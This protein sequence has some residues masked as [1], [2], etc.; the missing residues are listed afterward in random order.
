MT[1]GSMGRG[2][3]LDIVREQQRASW[4]NGE[5]VLV[6]TL[7]D[8]YPSLGG[9]DSLVELIYSEFCLRDSIGEEVSPVDY[10]ERFPEYFERLQRLFE[11]HEALE[12][13][14]P[15]ITEAVDVEKPSDASEDAFATCAVA[16]TPAGDTSA[17]GRL[18]DFELLDEIARGG[19]GVVYKAW[20]RGADRVVALK[21]ILAGRFA[22][23]VEI[24]RFRV[25]AQAAARLDHVNI[26]PIFSVGD[27]DSHP[28][29]AMAYIDGESLAQR[30][31]RGPIAPREASALLCDIASGVQYAHQSGIVH[32]DLK[33]ANILLTTDGVPKITDFG[34][35]KRLDADGL[36]ATGD[37]LGTPA[38]MAPEHALGVRSEPE[39]LG[40]I[41]SL[42]AILYCLLTGRPPF[43]AASAVETMKQVVEQ[44]PVAPRSMNPAIDRDI[45]TIC[46]KCLEKEPSRRYQ[47]ASDL[48]DDLQRY[49]S[50]QPIQA[51]QVSRVERMWRWCK[52]RPLVAMLAAVSSLL[53]ISLIAALAVGNV[54]QAKLRHKADDS[55][56][57]ARAQADL[58]LASLERIVFDI[59]R[60]LEH[61]PAAQ[62]VRREM[63]LSV[64]EQLDR[65]ASNLATQDL[66]DHHT[67]VA[68]V[69]L[70]D[71]YLSIGSHEGISG[72]EQ[73]R[74]AYETANKAFQRMHET[75]PRN[76]FFLHNLAISYGKLAKV[77][78]AR[79]TLNKAVHFQSLGLEH[80]KNLHQSYP[81]NETYAASLAAAASSL[82]ELEFNRGNVQKARELQEQSRRILLPLSQNEA[83]SNAHRRSLAVVHNFLG[84]IYLRQSKLQLAKESYEASLE[85]REALAGDSHSHDNLESQYD[86]AIGLRRYGDVLLEQADIEQ[87]GR[88]YQRSLDVIVRA[89]TADPSHR[90]VQQQLATSHSK[91]GELALRMGQVAKAT[92]HFEQVE[93]IDA[94][95]V[96]RH[97]DSFLDRMDLAAAK[98]TL[99]DALMRTGDLAAAKRLYTEAFAIL[100]DLRSESDESSLVLENY[101]A[102]CLRLGEISQRTGDLDAA[103]QWYERD[104]ALE[105]ELVA[106]TPNDHAK[107]RGVSV[108]LG[109]VGDLKL[110]QLDIDRA[111]ASYKE[112]LAI[113]RR[114]ATASPDS[115]QAQRDLFVS[116]AR[117]GSAHQN[118]GEYELAKQS[119][120]E[121]LE[122]AEGLATIGSSDAQA[123]EDLASAL[124][125]AAKASWY[126]GDNA[127]AREA[128]EQS[129][130][131][132][133]SLAQRDSNDRDSQYNLSLSHENLFDLLWAMGEIETAAR[134]LTACTEIRERL[135]T[136]S[137]GDMQLMRARMVTRDRQGWI[138][139]R[140][141]DLAAAQASYESALEILESML[142]LDPSNTQARVDLVGVVFRL[143][144]LQ[145]RQFEFAEA[146]E[147]F[148]RSLLTL[149]ELEHDGALAQQP[150]LKGYLDHIPKHVK[151]CELYDQV[152]SDLEFVLKQDEHRVPQLLYERS[153]IL[154]KRRDYESAALTIETLV[155][156]HVPDETESFAEDQYSAACGYGLCVIALD[157]Q[158]QDLA[159][160]ED[161]LALRQ[162]FV[163]RAEQLLEAAASNGYFL[164]DEAAA[165]LMED[166]DFRSLRDEFD[167]SRF[168]DP[169]A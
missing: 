135:A 35:A 55:A 22:T 112:S 50:N 49:L 136:A 81:K 133:E 156:L 143:A 125:G 146:K 126:C 36:T 142:E 82:G 102:T 113:A 77:E 103:A 127:S 108:G 163:A 85:L 8:E 9:D 18:A 100:D 88:F 140:H 11:V 96:R 1:D 12:R 62:S 69:E 6:E 131:I 92:R 149:R 37:I 167:S 107:W 13:G 66:A 141:G 17:L 39:V 83:P 23:E 30:V 2:E 61:V 90:V 10:L 119:F 86:L 124:A 27:D 34:L 24:Q 46:L 138:D 155:K 19:M 151:V 58:A 33:P 53:A 14:A 144:Y 169:E 99:G 60:K 63:L 120:T 41:Y 79:G 122:T 84:T 104:L 45:E 47:S 95:L 74:V 129:L 165:W 32:R 64:I 65:V 7:L 42:G 31:A 67:A 121:A 152:A 94:E 57:T 29:F 97:P 54:Y 114:L 28:Y 15:D 147:N 111:L 91:V 118:H 161:E 158:S 153:M 115:C 101:L 3:L 93:Q 164:D 70:G 73:A 148:D 44:E 75:D 43:Q 80:L 20:Q 116:L 168:V 59:Q 117:V 25:E 40:D 68:H 48:R 38:Y 21:M 139:E 162:R 89:A 137:H 51:R 106:K 150:T 105:R 72:E 98:Q 56:T 109:R 52:R 157:D 71:I 87:A 110:Q 123:D 134:H 132:R 130:A 160:R 145:Q 166:P 159:L 4:T 128:F 76:D 5:N 16:D 78:Q 26:V 154:A